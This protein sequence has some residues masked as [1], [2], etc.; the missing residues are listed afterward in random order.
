MLKFLK[1]VV[2]SSLCVVLSYQVKSDLVT[3]DEFAKAMKS[4]QYPQPTKEQYKAFV[5]GL[6]KGLISTK[7]E[8]A[9]ALAHFL[10]ESVGL[11]KKI[12]DECKHSGC[13][14]KYR[15]PGLFVCFCHCPI[16][17]NLNSWFLI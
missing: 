11:S 2:I 12:E 5:Q 7:E 14:G 4:N 10:H 8:A 17:T 1:I 15:V 13:P 6:P 16:N 3:Y 9:M